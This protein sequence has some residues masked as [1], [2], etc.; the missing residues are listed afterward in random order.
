MFCN[1]A[2]D[3]GDCCEK[4]EALIHDRVLHVV[5]LADVAYQHALGMSVC[6]FYE[7]LLF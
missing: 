6:F 3:V 2:L 5:L 7:L 4:F 1:Q